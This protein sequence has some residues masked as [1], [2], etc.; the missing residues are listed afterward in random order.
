MSQQN[1]GV[2]NNANIPISVSLNPG[3]GLRQST[4]QQPGGTTF[5]LNPSSGITAAAAASVAHQQQ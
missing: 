2:Q 4:H 5:I 3:I 1:D